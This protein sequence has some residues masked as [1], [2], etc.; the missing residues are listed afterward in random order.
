[1]IQTSNAIESSHLRKNLDVH[2]VVGDTWCRFK[3]YLRCLHLESFVVVVRGV[4]GSPVEDIYR[5]YIYYY[6][7]HIYVYYIYIEYT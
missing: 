5:M 4:M 1:M 2:G 6:I 7:L 3:V